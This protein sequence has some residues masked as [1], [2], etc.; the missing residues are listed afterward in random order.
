MIEKVLA[1]IT[2]LGET[3]PIIAYFK[4]GKVFLTIITSERIVLEMFENGKI[5]MNEQN[6]DRTQ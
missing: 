1:L 2:W 6:C 5:F 4:Q 3:K